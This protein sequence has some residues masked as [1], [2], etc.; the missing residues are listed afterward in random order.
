MIHKG[1]NFSNGHLEVELS[2]CSAHAQDN[3]GASALALQMPLILYKNA[4]PLC[5]F[6]AHAH[7]GVIRLLELG[8][9]NGNRQRNEQDPTPAKQ[10]RASFCAPDTL[11]LCYFQVVFWLRTTGVHLY[12][13]CD[14]SLDNPKK[15][16]CT[17]TRFFLRRKNGHETDFYKAKQ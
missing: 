11:K 1:M 15:P 13:V 5:F 10:R 4:V 16:Y 7:L 3:I 14:N 9:H 6:G 2:S 12:I 17:R 8:T